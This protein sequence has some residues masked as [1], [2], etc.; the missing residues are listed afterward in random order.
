[1]MFNVKAAEFKPSFA[2][3]STLVGGKNSDGYNEYNGDIGSSGS[4]PDMGMS[5]GPPFGL[6]VGQG[7]SREPT[8]NLL[9]L[10]GENGSSSDLGLG[11]MNAFP[12]NANLLSNRG[13]GFGNLGLNDDVGGGFAT[14][15]T[16]RTSDPFEVDA[17]FE[18]S[19]DFDAVM[20]LPLN[21][22]DASDNI[23]ESTSMPFRSSSLRGFE[24]ES[25]GNQGR[26]DLPGSSGSS[27]YSSSA[28][29]SRDSSRIDASFGDM[30]QNYGGNIQEF[31]RLTSAPL[32]TSSGMFLSSMQQQPH[33]ER[34]ASPSLSGQY[35]D[36]NASLGGGSF[37]NQPA[38]S[39]IGLDYGLCSGM[40]GNNGQPTQVD[41]SGG[42]L[43]MQNQGASFRPMQNFSS[44][45]NSPSPPSSFAN[46][47]SLLEND[48]LPETAFPVVNWLRSFG[49]FMYRWTPDASDWSLLALHIRVDLLVPLIGQDC[50]GL[51]DL[52]RRSNCQVKLESKVLHGSRENFLV[53]V[54]GHTGHP[55]NQ[56]MLIAL[57]MVGERLRF[58]LRG[59]PPPRP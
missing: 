59:A 30:Q 56:Y 45:N 26:N 6:D 17:A 20:R 47:V 13:G 35:A 38:Y 11:S 42:P 8:P 2:I 31:S 15:D 5:V 36:V 16:Y 50:S 34:F 12:G 58:V 4:V 53:F 22:D 29:P 46:A 41:Y 9:G 39:A 51:T 33:S 25:G 48:V 19:L 10:S 37:I 40:T 43:A 27:F 23:V 49:M 3:Q 21:F 1:M 24:D 54:R 57:Q 52:C 28:P 18:D 44:G 32:Q 7:M 14:T 55:A